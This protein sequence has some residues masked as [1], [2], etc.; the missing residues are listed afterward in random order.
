MFNIEHYARIR[1]IV[2]VNGFKRND[3]VVVDKN[4][5]FFS[6]LINQRLAEVIENGVQ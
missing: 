6:G 2:N 4:D 5:K 3:I 1:I